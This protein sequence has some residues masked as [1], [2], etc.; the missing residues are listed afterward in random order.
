VAKG[1]YWRRAGVSIQ[2]WHEYVNDKIVEI[3]EHIDH[4]LIVIELKRRFNAIET[5][6]MLNVSN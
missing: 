6:L 1:K 4:I 5:W 2:A 3:T